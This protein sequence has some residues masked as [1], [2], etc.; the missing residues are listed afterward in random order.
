MKV[1]PLLSGL[2]VVLLLGADDPPKLKDFTPK[3]GGF[4]ARVPGDMKETVKTVKG[5]GG[6]DEVQRTYAYAPNPST[7]YLILDREMP[8]LA[9]ANAETVKLALENGRKAAEK[10]LNGK[11][12]NQKKVSLGKYQGLEFLI[13]SAK[14]GVYRSRV[15]IVDGRMY[16]VTI[17]GPKDVATSKTADEYLESF[18]L[19]EKE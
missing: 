6:K 15:Y 13:E 8:A 1:R 19:R 18:K 14:Q 5:P 16:Q 11:L 17:L 12:L 3:E 9:K 4:S 10:S 7:V 2:A